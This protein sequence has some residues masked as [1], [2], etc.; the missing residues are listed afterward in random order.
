M[1]MKLARC[2]VGQ[3]WLRQRRFELAFSLNG[4]MSVLEK[5]LYEEFLVQARPETIAS[6]LA[7]RVLHGRP[8]A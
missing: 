5:A 3:A 2:L 8:D 6:T 7:A 1:C 4:T